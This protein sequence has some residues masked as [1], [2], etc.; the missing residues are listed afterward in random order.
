MTVSLIP[1]S[2]CCHGVQAH[3]LPRPGTVTSS[4]Q[5]DQVPL[6]GMQELCS[7]SCV[8]ISLGGTWPPHIRLGPGFPENGP[9][10]V[11]LGR[12]ALGWDT[13]PV[14]P[15]LA[16]RASVL[17]LALW[18]LLAAVCCSPGPPLWRYVSSEVVIPG[19]ETRGSKAFRLP[20]GCP[21]LHS[22][23]H[24]Y[25]IHISRKMLVWGRH[26]QLKTHDDQGALQ[27]DEP[28]VPTDCYYLG[29]VEELPLST[30]SLCT[31]HSSLQGVRK[32]DDLTYESDL[33]GIP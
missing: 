25:A 28:H 11:L 20:A 9:R 29:Y 4:P 32:L 19:K 33:S 2:C 22:G 14:E 12:I 17:L 23:G 5:G 16:L 21:T 18:A 13:R 15:R 1:Q 6:Y 8:L 7:V 31:C 27:T 10:P 30:V 26:L 3:T 24:R